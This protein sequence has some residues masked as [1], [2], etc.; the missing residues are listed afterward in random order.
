MDI[1]TV[2]ASLFAAFLVTVLELTEVVALVYALGASSRD[3][4]PG[5]YGAF[6]G[7]AFVSLLTLGTGVAILRFASQ[8]TFYL[9]VVSA[10]ILWCFGIFFFRSTVKT[11]YREARKRNGLEVKGK[12]SLLDEVGA[13]A[14][15][16][17]GFS[18]GCVET[19]EA[20]IVLL[21]LSTGGCGMEAFFGFIAGGVL[22]LVLGYML[23]EQIRKIK[24]APL[25]WFGCTMIFTF[26]IFW[27]GEALEHV[28]PFEWPT[29]LT[30]FPDIFL[31]PLFV[32][33]LVTVWLLVNYRVGQKI[34]ADLTDVQG[35]R[36]KAL[37]EKGDFDAAI[38]AYRESIKRYRS[39]ID[40]GKNES[41][42]GLADVLNNL[43]YALGE[44]GDLEGEIDS[45][46]ESVK[47]RRSLVDGGKV[48][49]RPD[50][51]RV[52]NNLG[53]AL[54]EQGDLVGAIS[55]LRESEE[56][57]RSLVDSGKEQHLHDLADVLSNLGKALM[58]KEDLDG[59]IE[60][61]KGSAKAYRSLI[62]SGKEQFISELANV[63]SDLG[64]A[65]A[66][67]DDLVGAVS[68]FRDAQE[69][70][71]ALIKGGKEQARPGLA[72]VTNRLEQL[73]KSKGERT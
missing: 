12:R 23:H 24:V 19:L 44:K 33:T 62:A 50:L 25:K 35:S 16:S 67:K 54:G 56:I 51:A 45:Y 8:A 69:A 34:T 61:Y 59:A 13:K 47:I 14:L 41:L 64:S 46:R 53:A 27:S 15:F 60:S 37:A 40:S 9:T 71:R 17:G 42:P 55:S 43:G 22:L 26:A 36:G 29:L 68:T 70:Y 58:D 6:I 28:G 52:L 2:V 7:V 48:E 5:V 66:E 73:L 31:V 4:R 49:L 18:I 39:Q 10:L 1:G 57:A 11:Y 30:Q 32:L 3:M 65:L 72:R 21:A 38:S 63:L 20:M